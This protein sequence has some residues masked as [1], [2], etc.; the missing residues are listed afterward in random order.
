M[1]GFVSV[2]SI[3]TVSDSAKEAWRCTHRTDK[4]P[5][6]LAATDAPG[7]RESLSKLWSPGP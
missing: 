5:T 3:G 1:V 4:K 2:F 7:R 6:T